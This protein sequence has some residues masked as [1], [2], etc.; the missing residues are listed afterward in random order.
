MSS[1]LIIALMHV[2]MQHFQTHDGQ[3]KRKKSV[4]QN[5]RCRLVYSTHSSSLLAPTLQTSFLSVTSGVQNTAPVAVKHNTVTQYQ[6]T[7]L[8]SFVCALFCCHLL[9]PERPRRQLFLLS[10]HSHSGKLCGWESIPFTFVWLFP[11]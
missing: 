8:E 3:F 7:S 9:C 11:K 10:I 1:S 6:V 5:Q 4:H 2:Y